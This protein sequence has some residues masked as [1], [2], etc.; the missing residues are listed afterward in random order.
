MAATQHALYRSYRKPLRREGKAEE[1]R[2]LRKQEVQQFN[3]VL[4]LWLAYLLRIYTDPLTT[5][6]WGITARPTRLD[7]WRQ[8]FLP[9]RD[10][11]PA[12]ETRRLGQG[13]G[14]QGVGCFPYIIARR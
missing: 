10:R 7:R 9:A 6:P 2:S 11:D 14:H 8:R 12:S 3:L 1:T 5:M 13:G 4:D